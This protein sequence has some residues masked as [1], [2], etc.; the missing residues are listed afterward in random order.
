MAREKILL[1]INFLKMKK[2]RPLL[3]EGTE[4]HACI[5]LPLLLLLLLLLRH[6]SFAAK[7]STSIS[8]TSIPEERIQ[9]PVILLERE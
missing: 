5:F 8:V 3:G 7:H 4:V 9:R 1:I 2:I 6:Y